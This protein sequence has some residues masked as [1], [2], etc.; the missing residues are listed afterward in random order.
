MNG[1]VGYED[2]SGGYPPGPAE[3]P[4]L[5]APSRGGAPPRGDHGLTAARLSLD[6]RIVLSNE[7]VAAAHEAA[8]EQAQVSKWDSKYQG[9]PKAS[10]PNHVIR[11]HLLTACGRFLEGGLGAGRQGEGY[12]VLLWATL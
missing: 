3:R 4:P 6:E 2:Y 5:R 7:R 8:V 11:R 1:R 10:H 12:P 9:N